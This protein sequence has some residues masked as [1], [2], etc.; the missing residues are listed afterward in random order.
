MLVDLFHDGKPVVFEPA[1]IPV[2]MCV[3]VCAHMCVFICVYFNDSISIFA[4]CLK[5]L[6]AEVREAFVKCRSNCEILR[7]QPSVL[8]IFYSFTLI[9]FET[10]FVFQLIVIPKVVTTHA[11]PWLPAVR[12]RHQLGGAASVVVRGLSG[13]VFS[14]CSRS[15]R[16]GGC[17]H[18]F[19]FSLV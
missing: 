13:R 11:G 2:F 5:P 16:D 9:S 19:C 10:S 8:F 15:L 7:A 6:S 12:L 17:C 3:C 4:V 1:S 18:Y 14:V